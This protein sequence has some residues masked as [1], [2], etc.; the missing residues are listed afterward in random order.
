MQKQYTMAQLRAVCKKK[1]IELD[2]DGYD[3]YAIYSPKGYMF[4]AT[5]AHVCRAVHRNVKEWKLK[6]IQDLMSDIKEGFR[7]CPKDCDCLMGR[8]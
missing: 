7:K 1:N 3:D 5:D 6:A 8:K 4:N 2:K